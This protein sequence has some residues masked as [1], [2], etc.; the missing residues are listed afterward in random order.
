MAELEPSFSPELTSEHASFSSS[1]SFPF[2][3]FSIRWD[4][5]GQW[6]Q[7]SLPRVV[8]TSCAGTGLC[9]QG[10]PGNA[11]QTKGQECWAGLGK[12][13]DVRFMKG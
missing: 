4:H 9:T 5:G 2:L 10:C 1:F 12:L 3:S 6:E 8:S 13:W 11:S 7:L